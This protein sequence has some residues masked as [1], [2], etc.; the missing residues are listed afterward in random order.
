MTSA[1][2]HHQQQH[3]HTTAL[4]SPIT[5]KHARCYS[6]TRTGYALHRTIERC[7]Q[8]LEAK[9]Y[10]AKFSGSPEQVCWTEVHPLLLRY[11]HSVAQLEQWKEQECQF[12]GKD[13]KKSE[14]PWSWIILFQKLESSGYI[15]VK[16]ATSTILDEIT[17][18]DSHYSHSKSSRPFF[19]GAV[20]Y[21]LVL[22]DWRSDL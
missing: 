1:H 12:S 18:N 17:R 14:R 8:F 7:L 5:P 9:F 13:R 3:Y 21:R 22:R 6:T 19:L 4:Y 20:L 16:K 11:P 15:S 2:H 10:N